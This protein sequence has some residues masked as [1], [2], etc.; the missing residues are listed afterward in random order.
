MHE[1]RKDKLKKKLEKEDRKIIDM[2][3]KVMGNFR[4]MQH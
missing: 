1:Y 3:N 2:F 4:A